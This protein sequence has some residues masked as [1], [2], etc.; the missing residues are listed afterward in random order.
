[1]FPSG[2]VDLEKAKKEVAEAREQVEEAL[3]AQEVR[4]LGVYMARRP[5]GVREAV[6]LAHK[7][8]W[9]P[10]EGLKRKLDAVKETE[11]ELRMKEFS[12]GLQKQEVEEEK[13]RREQEAVLLMEIQHF[14]KVRDWEAGNWSVED[15]AA[16]K[17]REEANEV[18]RKK[19]EGV[20]F[21]LA[22]QMAL[23]AFD[24]AAERLGARAM[25]EWDR[26][27]WISRAFKSVEGESLPSVLYTEEEMAPARPVMP[28][29]VRA[30]R[31]GRGVRGEEED[32]AIMGDYDSTLAPLRE[33]EGLPS[34]HLEGL[35]LGE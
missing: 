22:T 34:G 5:K 27:L 28:A 29:A 11:R 20:S 1:M 16:K 24:H 19:V 21:H 6:W 31:E 23:M 7:G 3:K 10:A 2:Q 25:D 26:E 35:N 12:A 13:N 14:L 4:D 17:F 15:K 33:R 32:P 8:D 18:Y 30:A 9:V